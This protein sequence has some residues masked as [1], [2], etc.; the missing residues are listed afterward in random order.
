[1]FKVGD[2]VECVDDDEGGKFRIKAGQ[3]Y[4]VTGVSDCGKFCMVSG[5]GEVEY[6]QRRFRPVRMFKGNKHA[7]VS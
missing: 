5:G 3:T 1:M 4:V 6:F 2:R 7:T